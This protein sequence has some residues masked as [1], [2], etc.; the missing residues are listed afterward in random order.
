MDAL[1]AQAEDLN[2]QLKLA[3]KARTEAMAS[4]RQS[5]ETMARQLEQKDAEIAKANALLEQRASYPSL[6]ALIEVRKLTLEM[7]H[8]QKQL[9]HDE[10]VHFIAGAIDEKLSGLEVQTLAFAPG[11]PLD[12]IP[13]DLLETTTQ[14]E[15]TNEP[16][17]ANTVVRTVRPAYYFEKDGKKSP[18]AKAL[19]VLYRLPPAGAIPSTPPTK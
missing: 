2:R 6:R 17:K 1:T 3:D 8:T 15:P 5:T 7:L 11:T 18:I 9:G 14:F 19:V 10:L 13:G 12:K 16:A 4:L